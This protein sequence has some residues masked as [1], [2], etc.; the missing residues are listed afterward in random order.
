MLRQAMAFFRYSEA[1]VY[2][3]SLIP[4]LD[5]FAPWVQG[6]IGNGPA[7][8][9]ILRLEFL[10]PFNLIRLQS[11]SPLL[12]LPMP[13]CMPATGQAQDFH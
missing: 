2:H 4:L 8:P 10:Q 9:G 12:A 13:A 1:N 3:N 7:K 6:Q 5:A 11:I